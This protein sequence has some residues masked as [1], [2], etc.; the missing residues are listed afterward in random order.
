MKKFVLKLDA[1]NV[2][3][4]RRIKSRKFDIKQLGY[5]HN[6]M[7]LLPKKMAASTC[8]PAKKYFFALMTLLCFLAPTHHLLLAQEQE[9]SSQGVAP[10]EHYKRYLV[11]RDDDLYFEMVINDL[12]SG[13]DSQGRDKKTNG[14]DDDGDGIV[15]NDHMWYFQI[16]KC[17]GF[18]FPE[19]HTPGNVIF[20]NIEGD[21]S[22]EICD[23]RVSDLL[24]KH[25]SL[26]EE[27]DS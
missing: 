8:W 15:D 4:E 23:E 19:G 5:V 27:D 6:I 1:L 24:S 3:N 22:G 7:Q 20:S 16:H 18:I 12:E 26:T 17:A 13:E 14:V 11:Y 2:T 9:S 10:P 25:V 21:D